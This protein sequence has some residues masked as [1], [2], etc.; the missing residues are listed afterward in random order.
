VTP[1]KSEK[2]LGCNAPLCD[3]VQLLGIWVMHLHHLMKIP[4]TT[5]SLNL[6]LVMQMHHSPLLS[7]EERQRIQEA[8]DYEVQGPG[9][10]KWNTSR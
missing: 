6:P 9:C 10:S 4:R 5:R 2:G 8:E 1:L 7:P 3:R